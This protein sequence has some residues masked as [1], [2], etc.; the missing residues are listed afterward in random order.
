[1]SLT[2]RRFFQP[3]ATIMWPE[4]KADVAPKFRGRLQLLYDE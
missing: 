2:L 1:M 4:E 3:K